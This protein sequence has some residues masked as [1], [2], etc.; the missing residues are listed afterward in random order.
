MEPIK[1]KNARPLTGDNYAEGDVN[2]IHGTPIAQELPSG[3]VGPGWVVAMR[4]NDE[5]FEKFKEHRILYY[6]SLG[7]GFVPMNIFVE[8]PIDREG[9]GSRDLKEYVEEQIKNKKQ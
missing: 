5:E 9:Y 6:R 7:E 1:L 4:M 3:K 8:N 2:T